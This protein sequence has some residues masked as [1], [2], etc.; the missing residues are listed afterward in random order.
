MTKHILLIDDDED[1]IHIFMEAVYE[2]QVSL[3]C[4]FAQGAE[5]AFEMLTHLMPDYIF[6]D[7]NMPKI[8][9][10][11][12]L[13]ELRKMPALHNVPVILYSNYINEETSKKALMVGAT[14][15]IKKPSTIGRLAVVLNDLLMSD[16]RPGDP[17]KSNDYTVE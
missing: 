6:L 16:G 11:T 10:L 12:C 9:G 14:A 7:F 2:L 1:E 5:Q 15:C 8:N 4:S 3:D 17:V 13:T